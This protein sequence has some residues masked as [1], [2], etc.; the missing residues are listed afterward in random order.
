M[1]PNEIKMSQKG[2]IYI[3]TNPSFPQYV[4]IGYADNVDQMVE[5]M[6]FDL[7]YLE[8]MSFATDIKIL[9]YTFLII[10][11]GRGK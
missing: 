10:F 11:Q 8:N 6:K 1:Y 9:L 7:L 4:K 5:R 3:L 2:V